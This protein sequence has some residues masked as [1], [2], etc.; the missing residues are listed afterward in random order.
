MAQ[1]DS[2]RKYN[3][4]TYEWLSIYTFL[5]SCTHV[6]CSDKH[7]ENTIDAILTAILRCRFKLVSSNSY[8]DI[9]AGYCICEVTFY[10]HCKITDTIYQENIFG[11]SAFLCIEDLVK[12]IR[13]RIYYDNID[14]WKNVQG[15]EH[16]KEIPHE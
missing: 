15:L 13:N 14:I 3:L 5:P 16:R 11:S 12:E 7:V 9:Y 8:R 1:I 2:L 10:I 4:S 6:L